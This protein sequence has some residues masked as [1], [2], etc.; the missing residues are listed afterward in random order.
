MLTE[1]D[2]KLLAGACGLKCIDIYVEI[3]GK[4][5]PGIYTNSFLTADD[6]ELV[7][8]KVVRPNLELFIYWVK[9]EIH[10]IK[11]SQCSVGDRIPEEALEIWLQLSIEERMKLVIAFGKEILGWT[12]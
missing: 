12:N 6:W 8:E 1:S 11:H 9:Y 3:D 5:I 7:L 2:R 10:C 4:S